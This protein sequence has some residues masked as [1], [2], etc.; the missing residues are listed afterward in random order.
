MPA[1]IKPHMSCVPYRRKGL[2]F[3]LTIPSLALLIAVFV[4]LWT[5]S[6]LLSTVFLSFYFAM[7]Y[8]QAYCCAYQDCPY[9]GEFCPAIGG[10][11]PANIL[12]KLIYGKRKIVKSRKRFEL[13]ATLASISWLGLIVFPLFWIAKL[14]VVFA[15]GYVACHVVYFLIFVLTI[16]PV[17][18]IRNTCPGGK[19]GD[20]LQNTVLKSRILEI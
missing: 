10:I 2:Y 19:F 4:Y 20:K 12:A 6:F 14:G 9:V 17:C 8:F 3:V 13:H 11:R 15:A 18:A 5:F 16:C 1:E 7:C